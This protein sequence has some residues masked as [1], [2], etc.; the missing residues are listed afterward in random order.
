MP[1]KAR[2]PIPAKSRYPTVQSHDDDD[3]RKGCEALMEMQEDDALSLVKEPSPPRPVTLAPA[4]KRALLAAAVAA[5]RRPAQEATRTS[6]SAAAALSATKPSLVQ[7]SATTLAPAGA[8][9]EVRR[10][11]DVPANKKAALLGPNGRALQQLRER[12]GVTSC[13]LRNGQGALLHVHIAGAMD[14]VEECAQLVAKVAAGECLGIGEEEQQVPATRPKAKAK[15]GPWRKLG[16]KGND[17]PAASRCIVASSGEVEELLRTCG[18]A[19]SQLDEV[20]QATGCT[21]E[22]RKPEGSSPKHRTLEVSGAK[23]QIEEAA[24]MLQACVDALSD[25]LGEGSKG[26]MTR[27]DSSDA[28]DDQFGGLAG[29]GPETKEPLADCRSLREKF[30]AFTGESTKEAKETATHQGTD[31]ESLFQKFAAITGLAPKAPPDEPE[32]GDDEDDSRPAAGADCQSLR[33]KFAA[34]T[35]SGP[36]AMMEAARE[37][38]GEAAEPGPEPGTEEDLVEASRLLEV[39]AYKRH[40]VLGRRGSTLERIREVSGAEKC[41]VVGTSF[42]SATGN[43]Q[44]RVAGKAASVDACA[45]LLRRCMAGDYKGIGGA[46]EVLLLSPKDLGRLL[47]GDMLEMLQDLVGASVDPESPAAGVAQVFIA[48][49]APHVHRGKRL[50]LALV[51]TLEV[52]PC[53]IRADLQESG[54][55]LRG[56]L[57]QLQE[58]VSETE[59]AGALGLR[60]IADILDLAGR[61]FDGLLEQDLSSTYVCKCAALRRLRWGRVAV[62]GDPPEVG[63]LHPGDRVSFVLKLS[64]DRSAPPR[65]CSLQSAFAS[66]SAVSEE[67]NE[68]E[69]EEEDCALGSAKLSRGGVPPPPPPPAQRQAHERE[70]GDAEGSK[71]RTP[72]GTPRPKW[73]PSVPSW[74]RSWRDTTGPQRVY[75]GEDEEAVPWRNHPTRETALDKNA[76]APDDGNGQEEEECEADDEETERRRLLAGLR[77]LRQGAG[78]EPG[79]Q[80][81]HK[82]TVDTSPQGTGAAFSSRTDGTG[83]KKTAA[84][85]DPEI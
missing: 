28:A 77:R 15:P 18:D 85:L 42:S 74:S 8:F 54:E 22:V 30:A 40:R 19:P 82:A 84:P 52:A 76:Q 64:S 21:V 59:D 23:E 67:E 37:P 45:R 61:R 9:E 72:R 58:R 63:L 80:G 27:Q 39:P 12:C 4:P 36:Q 6:T 7:E 14:R 50:I 70:S 1:A 5:A 78:D 17:V 68:E 51:K 2:S 79:A 26:G 83:L 43:L 49:S 71:E 3:L 48:G 66:A 57:H 81:Q 38:G 31:C 62:D 13:L 16:S 46:A 34:L 29:G 24:G 60:T 55:A 75:Y 73:D 33:A 10:V 56:V 35:G 25:Q 53:S 20:R 11:V 41:E 32:D 69:D 44:V 65:A 47:G